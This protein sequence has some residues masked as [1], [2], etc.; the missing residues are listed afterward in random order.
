MIRLFTVNPGNKR[1]FKGQFLFGCAKND[2]DEKLREVESCNG[3]DI[4]TSN[5]THNA[6][7]NIMPF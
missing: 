2:L 4:S 7:F 1:L 3:V 5:L 6:S